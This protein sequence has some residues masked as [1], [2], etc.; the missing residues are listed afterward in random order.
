MP[1]IIKN[2]L[3]NFSDTMSFFFKVVA[4]GQVDSI[5]T[6]MRKVDIRY[7]DIHGHTALYYSLF[8]DDHIL[9]VLLSDPNSKEI[10]NLRYN[11][12]GV[13]ILM[14]ASYFNKHTFILLLLESGAKIHLR[15]N[16]NRN[17]FAYATP[18]CA[19]LIQSSAF[20]I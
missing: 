10:I 20:F 1:H 16:L 14:L 11:R 19:K 15:D 8:Q 13:T 4:T 18:Y 3:L 5:Q 9:K 6:I 7:R 2:T 17:V 12:S